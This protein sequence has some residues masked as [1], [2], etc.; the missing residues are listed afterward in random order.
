MAPS[1]LDR[2]AGWQWQEQSL[3]E[4]DAPG[5]RIET[6]V[7]SA[8][9]NGV[10]GL[11]FDRTGRLYVASLAR[12]S[13]LAVDLAR[14]RIEAVV[15]PPYGQADD[16]AF[17]PDGALLWTDPD[18]GTIWTQV[19]G[20]VRAVATGLPGINGIA[21]RRDGRL[22]ASSLFTGDALY[23]I[24]PAGTHAP[25][26]I[27]EGIGGLNGFAFGPDDRLYGPLWFKGQIARIDVDSA[28]LEVI[29][30]GFM[31][32]SAVKFDP[33]GRLWVVD[34][35]LGL[36]CALD[37]WTGAITRTV[38]LTP[39]LDNLAID[40]TGRIY[41]TNMA[42]NALLRIDPDSGT[43]EELFRSDFNLPGGIAFEHPENGARLHVADQYSYRTV[44]V[45]AGQVTEIARRGGG[46]NNIPCSVSIAG[47]RAYLT[48]LR[49]R[50]VEIRDIGTGERLETI[51]GFRFPYQAIPSGDGI[52]VAD[53]GEDALVLVEG[54]AG[55]RTR[56]AVGLALPHATALLASRDGHLYAAQAGGTLTRIDPV[57]FAQAPLATGLNS[58]EGIADLNDAELL[59]SE[60][61]K[62]RLVAVNRLTGATRPVASGLPVGLRGPND[63]PE[64]FVPT[65]VAVGNDRCLYFSSDINC[66]LYRLRPIERTTP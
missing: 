23:E 21:F 48:S 19:A 25:R 42:D 5:Y 14:R 62:C 60:V 24:D 40:A 44:D 37:P 10:H 64:A 51:E 13:I 9:F 57:T 11:N 15:R 46:T 17:A 22:Y 65:G 2:S 56:R 41:V 52:L 20:G 66:A 26:P 3:D 50:S 59:V 28:T 8:P 39:S 32:P 35:G 12:R 53:Y 61:G 6:L 36:L 7:A 34:A 33:A 4:V 16:V 47:G 18:A 30:N 27:L 58:P 38:T 54:T 55:A 63:W 1:G 45:E 31:R 29:A 43:V 49:T